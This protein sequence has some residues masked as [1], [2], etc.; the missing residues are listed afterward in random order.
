MSLCI[1]QLKTK[2]TTRKGGAGEGGESWSKTKSTIAIKANGVIS[3]TGRQ[4]FSG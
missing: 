4:R 1:K 3:S 2:G